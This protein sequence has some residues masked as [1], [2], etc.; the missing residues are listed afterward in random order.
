[1]Q[2][3]VVA[4][5]FSE[6][7]ELYVARDCYRSSCSWCGAPCAYVAKRGPRENN[8]SARK[9]WEL[10]TQSDRTQHLSVGDVDYLPDRDMGAMRRLVP[11]EIYV[12]SVDVEELE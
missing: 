6:H 2:F 5:G 1:M 10:R 11:Y 7:E 9:R 4:G 3:E 12:I 8:A